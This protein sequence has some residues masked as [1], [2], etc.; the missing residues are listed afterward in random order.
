MKKTIF[1]L[2]MTFNATAWAQQDGAPVYVDGQGIMR[3]KK[4][5]SE[6][7]FF[8]VNYTVPF[9][10]GYRSH[11][12]PGID[13]RKAIDADV[14]HMHRL[15]LNAFRVHMWDVEISDTLGNLLDN[16]HLRLFDYL[17]YR[18]KQRKISVM[19]TP[20]AF[21]GNGYPQLDERTP[22]FSTRWGKRGAVV[23]EGAIRAQE[24]YLVQ[25]MNHVNPFTGLAY[26]DDPSIIAV[27][28][29]NEP[30][31]S[32]TKAHVTH[33]VNRMVAAVKSTGCRKPVFYNISESPAYADAVAASKA[34]GFSFQWYPT[35]LVANRSLQGNFLPH[36]DHYRIPFRDTIARFARRALMVYEF[37]AGD[38]MQPVMYPAMARSFRTAGFQWATQFAYDPLFTAFH[39]T[40]YQTHYLNLAYTPAKAISL[41]IAAR[42]FENVRRG[43][44]FGRYPADTA[45]GPF[46]I[47]P[48]HASTEMN[49]PTEFYYTASTATEPVNPAQ[50]QHLAGVGSSKMVKYSGSG[51][52]FLD[53]TGPGRWR[54]EVMPDVV[55]ISDPFGKASP[56]REVGRIYWK[57]HPVLISLPDLGTHFRVSGSQ[58]EWTTVNGAFAITPGVYE[59][60]KEGLPPGKVD[61]AFF[62]PPS[63]A[64]S[65]FVAH[66][67]RQQGVEGV[68]LTISATVA[69]ADTADRV[70]AVLEHSGNIWKTVTLQK[71]G[72][73]YSAPLPEEMR[74]PG[75]VT[76]R[77]VLRRADGQTIT[78]PG[79]V[80]GDPFAWDAVAGGSYTTRILPEASPVPL[81]LPE[82]DR[83]A[84]MP[85]ITEWT[86]Q[87]IG[88]RV[89]PEG[90]VI[91]KLWASEDSIGW[92][93][94]VG[95]RIA[96]SH[97]PQ[98]TFN[99][100]IIRARS[101]S[102]SSARLVLIDRWGRGFAAPVPLGESFSETRI[103]LSRFTA[104]PYLLLPR[105]YPRF[106]HQL[107]WSPLAAPPDRKAIESIQ[108]ITGKG[109]SEVEWIRMN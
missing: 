74:I 86:K 45:F 62:A 34:E 24:R 77:L 21:W 73:V 65:P 56:Q 58:R 98:K 78:F 44:A 30:Q 17:L 104:T 87:K 109:E 12:A 99:E 101:G 39:N 35:G 81:F 20:I 11:K 70:T 33:Y 3:W 10:Y 107:F 25:V 50:L 53:R 102:R 82:N 46:R 13:H 85:F 96:E 36:V 6:A 41:L 69:G 91:Q 72:Y 59:L 108:L 23:Q 14:Y 63:Y 5:K 103:P 29:N 9:A 7:S 105:P 68:P 100:V 75:I 31:H 43:E 60:V 93:L 92:Q 47:S 67:P 76:Y 32:G 71:E 49:S 26:K 90:Q 37:D 79:A 2:M 27:E 88:Y 28:I 18:L 22:G 83:H 66:T 54:L 95:E 80:P 51:A 57:E 89:G 42:I 16:E 55:L 84:L 38:V 48:F 64:G 61:T 15:G 97:S 1:F 52:Y 8:G 4:D 94:Y 40:E 19:L 106:Q